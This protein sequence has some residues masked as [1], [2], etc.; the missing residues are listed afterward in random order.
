MKKTTLRTLFTLLALLLVFAMIFTVAACTASDKTSDDD[1][2]G[3]DDSAKTSKNLVFS[4]DFSEVS[5]STQPYSTSSDWSAYTNG[6]NTDTEKKVAGIIDTGASYDSAKSAWGDLAN[7]S[8]TE[9]KFLMIYNKEANV[10][11]YKRS[12][13]PS[14][15]TYY[16]ISAKAK[17]TGVVGT[18]ASFIIISDNGME[19]FTISNS[20]EFATYTFY[21]LS[22]LSSAS[23]INV[24][25]TLGYGTD[26]VSGYVFF[27]DVEVKKISPAQYEEAQ[28]NTELTNVKFVEM[29]QPDGE[30]DYYASG[31]APY[32]PSSWTRATGNA[33]DGEALTT[34]YVKNGIISTTE[35]DWSTLSTS[36]A[37]YFKTNANPGTP[38]AESADKNVLAIRSIGVKGDNDT[39]TYTPTAI[40]Y[41]SK[42]SVRIGISTLYEI[43]VWVKASVDINSEYPTA[44]DSYYSERGAAV[45]L[46]GSDQY[47]ITGIRTDDKWEK[48]IFYVFGN[49]YSVKDFTIELWLG[50][51]ESAKTLTQGVAYFDKL[52]VKQ[53]GDSFSTSE[54][55]SLIDHYNDILDSESKFAKVV[56]LTPIDAN[57]INNHDFSAVVDGRPEGYTFSAIDNVVVHAGEDVIA[58][59]IPKSVLTAET[60]TEEYKNTYKID[61]NPSYPYGFSDVLLVN[62]VNPSA[63]KVTQD[64]QIE[65]KQNLHYRLSVWVKTLNFAKDD[66]L[67][68]ALVTNDGTTKSSFSVITN[69]TT[70]EDDSEEAETDYANAFTD[71]LSK[72]YVEYIFYI[73]GSNASD[74]NAKIK[75]DNVHL[76]FSFG[77]GTKYDPSG[78]KKGAY[79]IANVNMEQ[80]TYSEYNSASTGDYATKTN[81]ASDSATIDNGNFNEYDLSK[82]ELDD[83]TG[84]PKLTDEF[85]NYGYYLA[86]VHGWTNNVNEGYGTTKVSQKTDKD[87][88]S[89]VEDVKV[90]NL[91]AGILNIYNTESSKAYL[92]QFGL[93]DTV[94]F[95][96]WADSVIAETQEKSIAF[97]KPNVLMIATRGEASVTLKNTYKEKEE[98]EETKEND[99]TGTPAI[100]SPNI[101]LSANSYYVLKFYARAIDADKEDA[102]TAGE[103]Y[104][105]TSSTDAERSMHTIVDEGGWV[106]YIFLV[107]TGLSSVSANFE[108]YYGEKSKP[109]QRY[110]GTLLFDGFT[111][112]SIDK[113][114]YDKYL[115]YESTK[116]TK[117]TTTTFDTGSTT[118]ETAVKPALFS[119][120]GESTSGY[121]NSDKQVAGVITKNSFKFEGEESKKILG[122]LTTKTET[123]EEGKET[124]TDELVEG[125]AMTADAIFSAEGMENASVGNYLLLINNRKAGYYTY[126]KSSLTVKSKSYYKFSAYVRTAWLE[127]DKNALVKVTIG[128]DS[129]LIKVN[130]GVYDDEGK[131]TIGGWKLINFYIHNDKDSDVSDVKLAF[132]LGE[133]TDDDKLQGY[134]FID[135]VSLSTSDADEFGDANEIFNDYEKDE[136]TNED[137][138]VD[139]VKVQTAANKAFRLSNNVIE[140][141]EEEKTDDDNTDDDTDKEKTGINTTLLWTYITSI[142][143][144][145][146][147][148]AVIIVWLIKKYRPK[149]LGRGRKSTASYDRS[150]AAKKP[151]EEDEGTGSTRDEYKD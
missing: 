5:G 62:N 132:I 38:D 39:V 98:D 86:G 140:L 46:N 45:I 125:S 128:D 9:N 115:T 33:V 43:S 131:E 53:I 96:H 61:A 12:F 85:G 66:K 79:V 127:K 107:E 72:G 97:G 51:D 150:N 119:G 65:I 74:P 83:E 76:E 10:Y 80:I 41:T 103:V 78:F 102:L 14:T 24:Y 11:G 7:P 64:Q 55:Q 44:T 138:V 139:G 92:T 56:D 68:I 70:E 19:S 105:T 8:T 94:I 130:T 23:S 114:A 100:K 111:Y 109:D 26:K 20:D 126:E 1:S 25:L 21:V 142:A 149:N 106:E 71:L 67:T 50:T 49:D 69:D 52:V 120:T 108:I 54:R 63:Y 82:S 32:T 147:L 93:Q 123:D 6:S 3:D 110:A 136:E 101:S 60:W 48:V 18:G 37:D 42:T 145:A 133:N 15:A 88:P 17:A 36:Y 151:E 4:E 116:T 118:S 141:T 135:N 122:I 104:L 134:Y 34:S 59:M 73:Q 146:V 143:I 99:K 124:T 90:N 121:V 89:K 57:M 47:K 144:A 30:F 112:V 58:T 22:P 75:L 113:D 87:D 81:F 77:S 129:Y 31:S 95:D 27:D 13:T 29:L 2:N 117:F 40:G 84:L 28:S 16:T 137:K 35:D 148:I 91:L